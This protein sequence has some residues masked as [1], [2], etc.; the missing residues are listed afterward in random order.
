MIELSM[1]FSKKKEKKR[2]V[3]SRILAVKF[4]KCNF[5]QCLIFEYCEA[6]LT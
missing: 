6:C 2:C 1:R 4:I 5:Y 3:I